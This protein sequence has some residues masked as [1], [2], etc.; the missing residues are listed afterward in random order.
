MNI[1]FIPL[2]KSHFSLLIKWLQAPHVKMWWDQDVQWTPELIEKKYSDYVNGSKLVDNYNGEI[3]QKPIHA[4]IIF[5]NGIPIGYIQYYDVH[6]FPRDQNQ[7]LSELPKS[8]AALDLYIGEVEF[9]GQNF[10]SKSLVLFLEQY[11]FQKFDYAFVDPDFANTAAIHAYEKAGF[12]K[13]KSAKDEIW[14]II[15]K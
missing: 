10:G 8:C 6:V 11:V 15:E 5:L 2:A 13:I 1:T 14:M 4:Y 12:T 3:E 9:I 7:D